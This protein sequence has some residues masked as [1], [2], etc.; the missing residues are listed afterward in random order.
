MR[1]RRLLLGVISIRAAEKFAFKVTCKTI[2]TSYPLII[3]VSITRLSVILLE[4]TFCPS[5]CY[6]RGRL[7][8]FEYGKMRFS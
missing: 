8:G 7:N 1:E 6:I 4:A 5:I 2:H 3:L